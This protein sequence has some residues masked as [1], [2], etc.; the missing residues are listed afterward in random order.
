MRM[1]ENKVCTKDLCWSMGMIYDLR[2]LSGVST[3]GPE[4][5][6][7]LHCS[8]SKRLSSLYGIVLVPEPIRI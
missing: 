4:I 5:D 7:V 1:S 3:A 2:E 8:N 6:G